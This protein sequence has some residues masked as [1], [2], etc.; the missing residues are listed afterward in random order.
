MNYIFID[1]S[2][3]IEK[4]GLVSE[5]K[6]VEFYMEEKLD[7]K[8]LGNIYRGRVENI[9][10]GM[11]A[12]FLDIG[13]EKNSYLHLNQALPRDMMY[14]NGKHGIDEILV[15]GQEVIVQIT[16]EASG[17]K[18]ARVSRH[19]ELKGRYIVLTPYSKQINISKK[20]YIKAEI[21]RL[22]EIAESIIK[23]D[24]GLIFRTAAIDIESKS[25]IEEYNILL[26][27]YEKL[28]RE[29]NFLPCPKLIYSEPDLG[30]QV[31]RDLYDDDVEKIVIND[32]DYYQDLIAIDENYPFKFSD[33]LEL[34]LDFSVSLDQKLYSDIKTSLDR[35]VNLKSGAYL[36]VDQLEAL[37]VIDVNTGSFTGGRSL[38]DTVM[39]TNI[40]AAR[41]IA[42]QIRLRDIGGIIMIDFI[43]TRSKKDEDKLISMFKS[44]IKKDRNKTNF[45]DITKLG[46]VEL[47]R[48]KKRK[49]NISRYYSICEKCSGSGKIFIDI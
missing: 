9:V 16:K 39:K 48:S 26:E 33:K 5:D 19:I 18:G 13:E 45:I 30:Y 47:T 43:D 28:E 38:K 21:D 35:R 8:T 41:E 29:K 3:E 1:S 42:R 34:D 36:I 37:T 10:K 24:I 27:I 17:T 25:I 22:K 46:I 12:A 11:D 2:D 7:K 31:L 4:V 14:K 44:Y 32:K 49:S 15:E 40:E 20:I 23:D 6:L